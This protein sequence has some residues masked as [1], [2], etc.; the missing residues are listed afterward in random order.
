MTETLGWQGDADADDTEQVKSF[1]MYAKNLPARPRSALARTGPTS[2]SL[3]SS[4]LPAA[5]TSSFLLRDS[6]LGRAS[7]QSAP[8][9]QDRPSSSLSV[10]FSKPPRAADPMR[11]GSMD[12]S[13]S[14][15]SRKSMKAL[16]RMAFPARSSTSSRSPGIGDLSTSWK[17]PSLLSEPVKRPSS[18]QG[19]RPKSRAMEGRAASA[20]IM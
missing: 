15:G 6:L 12:R 8:A 17:R 20:T 9:K 18:S 7:S 13:S 19:F 2:T 10:T 16:L 14:N 11:Q 5:A 1:S 4:P 3:S